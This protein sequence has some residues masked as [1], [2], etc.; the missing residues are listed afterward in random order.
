MGDDNEI[1]SQ[2]VWTME[3]LTNDGNI[4]RTMMNGLEQ[5]RQDYKKFL[6]ARTIHSNHMIQYH[7]QQIMEQ[8]KVVDEYRSM[9]ED[10]MDLT[11]LESNLYKS[12]PAFIL[13]II[14]MNPSP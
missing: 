10:G 11:P 5:A 1:K 12:D 4:S 9:M 8:Q 3:M 14:H 13:H 2:K 6:C 7:M